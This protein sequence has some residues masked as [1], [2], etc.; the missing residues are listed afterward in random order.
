[1][2]RDHIMQRGI[3]PDLGNVPPGLLRRPH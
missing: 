1:L 2:H 3:H